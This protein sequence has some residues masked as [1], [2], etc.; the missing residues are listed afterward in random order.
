MSEEWRLSYRGCF[1]V[2]NR[3]VV[4][5]AVTKRIYRPT[6]MNGYKK[7][8]L[9]V[10]VR[11]NKFKMFYVHRLVAAAF[12]GD[13]PTRKHEV[14][15]LNGIRDDNRVENLQWVTRSENNVHSYEHLGR[16]RMRGERSGMSIVT[17]QTVREMR[18]L[19]ERGWMN[20]DI[21]H[22]YG[23]SISGT[24]SIVVGER[25]KHLE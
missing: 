14:N 2:S 20:K 12:L 4:R 10:G 1:E 15:H 6:T 21:A 22:L 23:M 24:R 17:E 8:S 19:R 16:E 25:W 11:T 9:S 18:A 5:H 13:P 7:V 3:G